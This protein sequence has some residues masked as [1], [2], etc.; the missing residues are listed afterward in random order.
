MESKEEESMFEI[1]ANTVKLNIGGYKYEALK[2]TLTKHESFFSLMINSPIS[3]KTDSDG[4]IY[5]EQDGQVFNYILEY[6]KTGEIIF[7]TNEERLNFVKKISKENE[8]YQIPDIEDYVYALNGKS[9]KEKECKTFNQWLENYFPEWKYIREQEN[10]YRKTGNLD[11]IDVVDVYQNRREFIKENI[12]DKIGG[13]YYVDYNREDCCKYI[14]SDNFI[15]IESTLDKFKMN[16]NAL[17]MDLF[18]DFNWEGL[19]VAGGAIFQCLNTFNEANKFTNQYA[20]KEYY[21]QISFSLKQY[22]QYRK[23]WK[24]EDAD[25]YN[26]YEKVTHET[27]K[28]KDIDGDIDIFI[29]AD[30]DEEA[31]EIVK[32]SIRKLNQNYY[33]QITMGQY[34]NSNEQN[35]APLIVTNRNTTSFVA[36]HPFRNIQFITSRRYNNPVQIIS[37]FDIDSCTFYYDGKNVYTIPRG[38]RSMKYSINLIDPERQSF[39]Y[40]HRLMKYARRG[41]LI[42]VPGLKYNKLDYRISNLEYK[43]TEGLSR[44]IWL[45]S[46]YSKY[47]KSHVPRD[48]INEFRSFLSGIMKHT[49]DRISRMANNIVNTRFTDYDGYNFKNNMNMVNQII[50]YESSEN[51]NICDYSSDYCH[52]SKHIRLSYIKHKYW[53]QLSSWKSANYGLFR[54]SRD[55]EEKSWNQV[56][57][58]L[59]IPR[60]CSTTFIEST[61]G[62]RTYFSEVYTPNIFEHFKFN[63]DSINPGTQII[64]GR[65][66]PEDVEYYEQAFEYDKW[67]QEKR[68]LVTVSDSTHATHNS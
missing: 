17:T 6:L 42:I 29:I 1:L 9:I 66:N 56:D 40:H 28:N 38:V 33:K 10:Q 61:E 30:T 37:G 46:K 7:K 49:S 47:N 13:D 54:E 4:Y 20:L 58:P 32:R 31:T 2:E 67:V 25:K 14:S 35:L 68:T 64:D 53:K 8:F 22:Y 57:I 19:V 3:S 23:Y 27:R 55:H 52:Y 26:F 36:A 50:D 45:T 63:W 12:F 51:K 65:F 18:E 62:F 60:V 39:S 5:I 41:M 15:N 11:D 21:H 44:L 43:E 24:D 48:I 34:I 16:F 59:D